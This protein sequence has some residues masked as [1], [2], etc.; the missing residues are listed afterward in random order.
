MQDMRQ[1][2][3]IVDLVN[4]YASVALFY[5]GVGLGL[6]LAPFVAGMWNALRSAR[7]WVDPDPGLSLLGATVFAC[8]LG[9]AIMLA[10]GSFGTALAEMYYVLIGIAAGYTRLNASQEP[11]QIVPRVEPG[12][13]SLQTAERSR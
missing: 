9:T 7:R 3:G 6:F 5:G 4:T 2:Q 13:Q 10:T 1:G 11:S 8:M 12:R